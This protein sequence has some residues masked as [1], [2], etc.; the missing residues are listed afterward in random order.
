MHPL[1]S[2]T[3]L[4]V[5]SSNLSGKRWSHRR[6]RAVTLAGAEVSHRGGGQGG[7]SQ[8]IQKVPIGPN[9]TA[10]RS[11]LPAPAFPRQLSIQLINCIFYLVPN[12]YV[13]THDCAWFSKVVIWSGFVR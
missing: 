1:I 11:Q 9:L 4:R 10:N 8:C 13:L 7:V 12:A 6:K 2:A 3:L 5:C